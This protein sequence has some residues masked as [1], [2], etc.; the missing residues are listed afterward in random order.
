MFAQ[1]M[2]NQILLPGTVH[3]LGDEVRH[4]S[5]IYAHLTG[6]PWRVWNGVRQI[7]A[8]QNDVVVCTTNRITASLMHRLFVECDGRG[9]PGV[10]C[11]RTV[12]ELEELCRRHASRLLMPVQNGSTRIFVDSVDPFTETRQGNDW[13]IG[14]MHNL[15]ELLLK[16]SA[17][18][19]LLAVTGQTMGSDITLTLRKFACAFLDSPPPSGANGLL[20]TCQL[21]GRCTMFP[22]MPLITEAQEKGWIVPLSVLRAAIGIFCSCSLVRIPDEVMDPGYALGPMLLQQTDFRAIV[23]TWRREGVRGVHLNDLINDLCAGTT[24]G[25]AVG[26]FNRLAGRFG[27]NLCV[28]GDPCFALDPNQAFARLPGFQ[29]MP[30]QFSRQQMEAHE[31]TLAAEAGLLRATVQHLMKDSRFDQAKGEKLVQALLPCQDAPV[32]LHEAGPPQDLSELDS[33]LLEFLSGF[34]V[35]GTL[36]GPFLTVQDL[37]EQGICPRCHAP[38]RSLRSV[39]PRHGAK[40]RH[41]ISCARCLDSSNLPDGWRIDLDLSRI[42]EGLISISGVRPG[43]HILVCFNSLETTRLHKSVWWQDSPEGWLPFRLPQDLPAIPLF[44]QVL[45]AHHLEIGAVGF[46]YRP[47]IGNQPNWQE[48]AYQS[49]ICSF[50]VGGN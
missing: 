48:A 12:P 41:T 15:D 46:K 26:S 14:G 36:F 18:A 25:V 10:I 40:P 7:D 3:A 45:I 16:L 49:L 27:V 37:T 33:A 8:G 35:P 29:A 11:S 32:V 21:L 20:P 38:A 44:C 50:G 30:R 24:T 17:G 6:R 13:F 23:T 22:K 4:A 5:E 2:N 1:I 43:S 9:V 19:A 34:P 39:F 47:A 28:L 42:N 31:S